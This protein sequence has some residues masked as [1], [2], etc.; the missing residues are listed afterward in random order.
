MTPR[1][2]SKPGPDS[3]PL[4]HQRSVHHHS[5]KRSVR[6]PRG[7]VRYQPWPQALRGRRV[8]QF[9]ELEPRPTLKGLDRDK[10]GSP[11]IRAQDHPPTHDRDVAYFRGHG[12]SRTYDEPRSTAPAPT[13]GAPG[14]HDVLARHRID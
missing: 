3:R 6:A 12:R 11:K 13:E 4:T 9:G 2:I 14:S 7:T 1:V 10:A 8:S 5:R